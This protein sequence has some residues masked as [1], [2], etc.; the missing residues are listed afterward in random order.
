M[1]EMASIY[2]LSSIAIGQI[3]S[4]PRLDYTIPHKAFEAGFFSKPYISVQTP[5]LDE[6]FSASSYCAI[7]N[8]SAEGIRDAVLKLRDLEIR[9]TLAIKLKN[10][11]ELN[12]SQELIHEKFVENIYQD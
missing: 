9:K 11:Y 6:I 3:S 8:P 7:K 2:G 12:C 10:D 5:G 1:N 4:H